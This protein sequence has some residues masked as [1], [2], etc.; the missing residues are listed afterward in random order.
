[1]KGLTVDP[2]VRQILDSCLEQLVKLQDEKDEEIEEF[3][4]EH[5]ESKFRANQEI[6]KRYSVKLALAQ[7]ANDSEQVASLTQ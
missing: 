1:M 5:A 3:M 6:K 7:K 2:S 4:E